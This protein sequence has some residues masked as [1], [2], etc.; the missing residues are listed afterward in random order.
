MPP[1]ASGP[2]GAESSAAAPK[3]PPF[4]I[5]HSELIFPLKTFAAAALALVTRFTSTWAALTGRSQRSLSF[6]IRSPG[7]TL[8]K[9]F[10]RVLGTAVGA[11]VAVLSVTN[12]NEAPELLSLFIAAWVGLCVYLS[13]IGHAPRPIRSCL[14]A[15]APPSSVSLASRLQQRSGTRPWHGLNLAGIVCAAVVSML[16]F[17]VSV[18]ST[19]VSRI[20]KWLAQARQLGCDVLSR[21]GPEDERGLLR[22]SSLPK[23]PIS[24][25]WP[26]IS[27]MTRAWTGK[28]FTSSTSC[29]GACSRKC[30]SSRD[31][32]LA[33]PAKLRWP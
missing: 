22:M 15:T 8:S 17:P 12:L 3:Q 19:L 27:P 2:R 20:E 32:G 30:P 21:S 33:C 31:R 1:P 6:P 16:V 9:A 29:T 10:Y 26:P 4:W 11:V 25:R 23:R 5:R 7:A 28:P 24:R 14:P 13:L 18:K